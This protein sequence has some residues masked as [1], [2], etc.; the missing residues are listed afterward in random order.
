MGDVQGLERILGG[1]M[2]RYKERVP[3]VDK[4]LQALVD[5]GGRM[6]VPYLADPNTGTELYESDD[7]CEY[8]SQT[9]GERS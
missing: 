6:M 2:R 9:Y 1:L 4:I 7:I 5:R 3:D 8:L